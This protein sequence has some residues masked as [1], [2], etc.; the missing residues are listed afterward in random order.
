M[1]LLL[2]L[3]TAALRFCHR[4]PP[5][6]HLDLKTPNILV[7]DRWRVKITDFGLSK[8]RASTFVSSGNAGG[9]SGGCEHAPPPQKSSLDWCCRACT[10]VT[11]ACCTAQAVYVCLAGV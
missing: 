9:L 5:I 7:D 4:D 10:A 3:P 8:A 1:L 2:L 11:R 6:M